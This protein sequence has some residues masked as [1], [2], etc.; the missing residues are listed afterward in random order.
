M[1]IDQRRVYQNYAGLGTDLYLKTVE[2]LGLY[3][4]TT[5]KNES[6]VQVFIEAELLIL[7][8]DPISP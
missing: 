8:E 3:V 5:Y 4:C 6:D 2:K 1:S 7:H